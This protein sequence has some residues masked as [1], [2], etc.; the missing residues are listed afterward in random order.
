M[1]LSARFLVYFAYYHLSPPSTWLFFLYVVFSSCLLGGPGDSWAVDLRVLFRN[2]LPFESEKC[3][4]L[5][6]L[7]LSTRL[8]GFSKRRTVIFTRE[9]A[10]KIL[11]VL[12][13]LFFN[14][15]CQMFET[16]KFGQGCYVDCLTKAVQESIVQTMVLVVF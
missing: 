5:G 3:R 8:E 4:Q 15:D 12:L 13:S 6:F 1:G 11:T 7:C 9:N 14:K 2:Y 16:L 10:P